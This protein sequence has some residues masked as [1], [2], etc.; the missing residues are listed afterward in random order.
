M[1]ADMQSTNL[2]CCI[3]YRTN[4]KY[5]QKLIAFTLDLNR[6]GDTN[7]RWNRLI[8]VAMGKTRLKMIEFCKLC[9]VNSC[10]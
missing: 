5:S 9:Q 1:Q 10:Q 8:A 3:K 4:N 7:R 6:E 2:L